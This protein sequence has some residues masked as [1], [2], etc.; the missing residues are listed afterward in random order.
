MSLAFLRPGDMLPAVE[1]ESPVRILLADDHSMVREGTRQL[2]E[3]VPGFS[4]VG[5]AGRGDEAV[6]RTVELRPD[7]VVLD[8]RMPGLNGIEATREIATRAPSTKVL[9]V[10]AYNDE[11]YVVEA[12]RAGATGYLLK[13]APARELV[14][15]VRSVATG[16]MTLGA[17]V[18]QK[19]AAHMARADAPGP[20]RNLSVREL[21]VLRLIAQGLANKEI[22]ARLHISQRTVEGHLNNIF[23]KLG[24]ASRTEAV[25]QAVQQHLIDLEQE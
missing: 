24:A 23:D 19:L 13:T 16:A 11:D 22:A 12:L 4:V 7:V 8:L 15:A 14:N 5:E 18:S 3:Q 1:P 20:R 21:E 25:Y 2:L 9:I 17:E 10:S 6:E